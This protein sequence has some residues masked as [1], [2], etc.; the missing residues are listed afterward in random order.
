MS[1]LVSAYPTSGGIYWWA[2]KLGGA[3]AGFYT[4]WLNLVGLLAIEASVAY[5]TATFFDLTLGTSTAQSW[6]DNYSLTRVFIIFVVVLFLVS[7]VNIFSSHLLAIFNNISVWW[8]V[9]G[10]TFVVGDPAVRAEPPPER[11]RRLHA[12]RS[13]TPGSSAG[14]RRA[15][16]SS[17]TCSRSASS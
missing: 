17:S 13:T 5:G 11:R 3:R 6:A 9:A 15:G 8:H 10:A 4:G 12:P 1:E 7:L 14:A 2:S 16:A